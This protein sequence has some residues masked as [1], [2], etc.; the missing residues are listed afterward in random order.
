MIGL[1]AVWFGLT[2]VPVHAYIDPGSG[3][4][5]FQLLIGGALAGI[6]TVAA[7]WRSLMAWLR[8]EGKPDSSP[9]APPPS[10]TETGGAAGNGGESAAAPPR[11]PPPDDRRLAS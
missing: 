11:D 4:Y 6:Y 5:L 1:L 8:G 2:A 9:V 10:R 3:S 7:Y